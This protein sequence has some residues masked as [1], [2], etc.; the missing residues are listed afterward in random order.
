[1]RYII[2]EKQYK[3]ITEQ[4]DYMMDR[5]GNALLNT[6]GIRSDKDY[7]DV[8][9]TINKAQQVGT[10]D[11]HTVATIFQIGTAFIPFIGPF[12]SA[13]IGLADA[14]LYYKEGDKNAAGLTAA[15]SM[16]P[17]AGKLASKIPGVKQLGAKGM[18]A[19]ST[20]IAK[21]SKYFTQAEV[22]ILN[23]VTKYRNEVQQQLVKMAPK[24]TFVMKEINLYKPNFVKKYG[25]EKYNKILIEYL[26]G[27][28]NSKN[29]AA[30]ISKLKGVK[31]PTLQVKPWI[32]GGSDHMVFQS[33]VKPNMVFKAELRPGEVEKWYSTFKKYPE[34]FAQPSKIVKVKGSDGKLLNAVAIEKL[35]TPP[36]VRLWNDLTKVGGKLKNITID[37]GNRGLED[38][39]KNLGNVA[40]KKKWNDIL[41]A[42]KKELPALSNKIDEFN[43]MINKLYKIT[44]NPD[45]RQYNL[46][47]DTKGVLKALDI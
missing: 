18:A 10:I 6:T 12:I 30:F 32:G 36:F 41:V 24:L 47:Y 35:D 26:Y 15:L 29:K 20:K 21:G 27:I 19:L 14:A 43:N 1:M 39:L 33:V 45:I 17:F 46:G 9:K 23:A 37:D 5:R 28:T 4:S 2:S 11:P 25:E 22:E 38:V 31:H 8:G 34:V 13:G 16:I 7:K 3:V 42:A 40:N 44:P